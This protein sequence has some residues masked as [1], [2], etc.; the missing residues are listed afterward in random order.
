MN[1]IKQV[2]KPFGNSGHITMDKSLIGEMVYIFPEVF[3]EHAEI[4][5]KTMEKLRGMKISEILTQQ[6][7]RQI[8]SI[9]RKKIATVKRP[10]YR[11]QLEKMSEELESL[12]I[13]EAEGLLFMD[14]IKKTT[15]K[16][17]EKLYEKN[18]YEI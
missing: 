3:G 4:F 7:I 9:L 15:M 13:G 1:I 8:K 12:T 18:L 16:K 6:E 5:L 10:Q 11:E 2:V 14:E 17:L